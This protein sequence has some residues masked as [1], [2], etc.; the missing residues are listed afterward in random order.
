MKQAVTSTYPG[1]RFDGEA[2]VARLKGRALGRFTNRRD[3]VEALEHETRRTCGPY[4]PGPLT[5][6]R[7]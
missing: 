1:I 6:W 4:T 5:P 7:Y 3:A 2:W